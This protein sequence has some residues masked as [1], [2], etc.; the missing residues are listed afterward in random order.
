MRVLGVCMCRYTYVRVCARVY[1]FS[2]SELTT[3]FN[4]VNTPVHVITVWNTG[5][6]GGS[7]YRQ[8]RKGKLVNWE[9]KIQLE[10]GGGAF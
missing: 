1:F 2:Y 3:N 7:H 10:Q 5:A 8:T 6:A 9:E 4:N